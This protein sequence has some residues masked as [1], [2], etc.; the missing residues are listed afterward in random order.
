LFR[1]ILI[2]GKTRNLVFTVK[3][4]L[5]EVDALKID[6]HLTDLSASE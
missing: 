5:F 4:L 2:I 1:D 6:R 3:D